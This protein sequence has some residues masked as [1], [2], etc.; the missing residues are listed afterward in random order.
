MQQFMLQIAQRVT[1]MHAEGTPIR[2]QAAYDQLFSPLTTYTPL[3]LRKDKG[4]SNADDPFGLPDATPG[5]VQPLSIRRRAKSAADKENAPAAGRLA[6]K[7]AHLGHKPSVRSATTAASCSTSAASGAA[8]RSPRPASGA[9]STAPSASPG[10]TAAHR[11]GGA[12]PTRSRT[13]RA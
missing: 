3:R 4:A 1:E 13:R 8:A 11:P 5:Q 7:G 10:L 9:R 12:P 2:D 6:A